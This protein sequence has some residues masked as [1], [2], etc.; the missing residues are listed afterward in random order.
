MSSD[1]IQTIIHHPFNQEL[2]D[3]TLEQDKFT[4]YIE[5][6][7]LYLQDFARCHAMIASKIDL[8]FVEIFLKYAKGALIAEQQG[9]HQFFKQAFKAKD[10]GKITPAL[11]S[12][13]SYLLKTCAMEPVEVAVAA[14]LPCFW[15]Y[16][17]V[18]LIIAKKSSVKNPYAA[19]IDVYSG[20]DFGNSVNEAILIFDELSDKTDDMTRQKMLDAF[21]K[22]TCLEWHFW[23]DAYHKTIFGDVKSQ[24]GI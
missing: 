13:T 3:G 12:Y 6:D 19:W 23:Q 9:V 18:G 20:E 10:T 5:Q 15:I 2:M 4:F 16:K 11:L 21:Y 24:S 22:S 14:V 1:I 8:L 7:A 17:E